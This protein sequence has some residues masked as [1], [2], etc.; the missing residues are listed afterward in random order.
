[1]VAI[2]RSGPSVSRPGRRPFPPDQSPDLT[3]DVDVDVDVDVEA[4]SSRLTVVMVN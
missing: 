2:R 1:M 3:V 4:G